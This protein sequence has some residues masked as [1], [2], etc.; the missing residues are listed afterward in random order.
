MFN[1]KAISKNII[2]RAGALILAF[3]IFAIFSVPLCFATPIKFSFDDLKLGQSYIWGQFHYNHSGLDI[4][5]GPINIPGGWGCRLH[6]PG[7]AICVDPSPPIAEVVWNDDG[8]VGNAL[9][10][11]QGT[12]DFNFSQE[13]TSFSM[14]FSSIQVASTPMQ[15]N[16]NGQYFEVKHLWDLD[17]KT[18][19]GAKISLQ[20]VPTHS[21][22]CLSTDCPTGPLQLVLTGSIKDLSIGSSNMQIHYLTLNPDKAAVPE[23]SS[24]ALLSSGLLSLIFRRK[25]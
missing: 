19:G 16:I 5:L 10:I 25:R 21:A 12:L 6:G 14:E 8:E 24:V 13:L 4:S 3:I 7:P 20:H 2:I 17:G 15:L 9:K 18:L 11:K 1:L 23:P 22:Y